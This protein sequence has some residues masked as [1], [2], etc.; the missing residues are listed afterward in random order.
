MRLGA[1]LLVIALAGCYT[2]EGSGE[3]VVQS[4][5][6]DGF[7]EVALTGAGQLVVSEGDFAVSASADDNVLPSLRVTVEDG[8]LVLGREVDWVDGVRPTVPI[9]FR[10]AMPAVGAVR[11]AGNGVAAVGDVGGEALRLR[12][13]GSGEIRAGN[14]RVAAADIEVGGSGRVQVSRLQADALR[15]AVSGSGNVSIA[16]AAADARIEINGSGLYRGSELRSQTAAVQVRGSGKAF[17]WAEQRLAASITGNGR[18]TYR[19]AA[20]VESSV[21]GNGKI[22]QLT[23][24]TPVAPLTAPGTSADG[25]P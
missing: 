1:G 14:A 10:V 16:G 21:Q 8:V 24:L 12:V 15:C 6:L 22:T 17:V 3:V 19:G 13:S 18:V 9:E 7:T 11:V 25:A 2:G 23:P 20:K 4:Y 5:D